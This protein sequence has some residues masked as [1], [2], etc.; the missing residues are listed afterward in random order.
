M[1]VSQSRRHDSQAGLMPR[2][3]SARGMTMNEIIKKYRSEGLS[4][5]PI[6]Y[7]SKQPAIEW[8]VYQERIPTA[9][10]ISQWFNGGPSNIAVVCGKVSGNLV[11]LDCDSQDKFSEMAAIICQNV[12]IEDIRNFTRISQTSRG[13]H[14]WLRAKETLKS[15][16]F[17][18]LDIK[19]EGGYIIV[20]PSVHPSGAQ[21]Q[22]V[23]DL[24]IAIVDNLK[25]IGIDIEPRQ[26]QSCN[27]PGWVS[28]LLA[29][30]GEGRRN[31]S[32][33]KLTGYFRNTL[34]KEVTE[35][36]LLDWNKKNKPPMPEGE[37]LSVIASG[38]SLPEHPP[39]T[40]NGYKDSIYI[41]LS[42]ATDTNHFKI[43]SE[44]ISRNAEDRENVSSQKID[45]WIK[46]TSGWFEISELDRDLSINTP[47]AKNIRRIA[48]CR[49]TKDG[50]IEKHLTQNKLYRRVIKNLR[51]IDFKS[52]GNRQPLELKLP[53]EIEKLVNIYPGNIIVVAGS[54]DAGKTAWL[55][56]LVRL[57]MYNFSIYYFSSEMGELELGKR[58]SKFE[59]M[60]LRDWNFEAEECTSNF[61]DVIRPDAINIIDYLELSKDFFLVAEYL[62][63]IHDKLGS[64][65]AVV[66]LQKK[67]GADLGRGAEFSLEKPR[68]YLSMDSGVTTIQK[69]KN[70]VKAEVNPNQMKINYKIVDGC[71][72]IITQNWHY[73][74]SLNPPDTVL[75][76]NTVVEYEGVI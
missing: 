47:Q 64:G 51:K 70:R 29:G 67:R 15:Q 32:A 23:N 20:P 7:K 49:L 26:E 46:E 50:V 72:F 19:S 18:A 55:L 71:K 56:N 53:F 25:L 66:A 9:T 54:P 52:A 36:I 41:P 76:L 5:F 38:Y 28:Q 63:S 65:I 3:V 59:G 1:L 42:S 27:Q 24:P 37:L 43:I 68:L 60:V 10:E 30:V 16:K 33:I 57:N 4:F 21:Y 14:I 58:L 40:P 34:P 6:P 35:S 69:A 45:D 12:G 22:L 48:I 74:N 73:P 75:G 44:N 62:K 8:R 61:A 31:D 13:Y 11:V 39:R 17:T 2:L